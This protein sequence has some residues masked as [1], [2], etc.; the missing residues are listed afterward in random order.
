[1]AVEDRKQDWKKPESFKSASLQ[2]LVVA[3]LLAGAVFFYIQRG[4]RRKDIADL[5]KETRQAA[6]RDNPKDLEKALAIL[7]GVFR[8][9]SSQPDA[10][11]VA[12]DLHMER[13]MIHRLPGEEAKARDSLSKSEEEKS[14]VEERFGT[15][16]MLF[17]IDG[18]PR[19]ATTF[20]EDLRKRGASSARLWYVLARSHQAMGELGV[21]KQ[22]FSQAMDKAWKDP[23]FSTG[24]GEALIEEGQ[25]LHAFDAF[26]KA[27]SA[28]PDHFQAR[29]GRSLAAIY[30]KDRVKEAADT[31]AEILGREAELSPGLLARALTVKAELATFEGRPDDA[32]AAAN[33]ALSKNPEEYFALFAKAHALAAKKDA[34]TADAFNAAIAKRKTAPFFYFDAAQQLQA[35]G[36][37]DVALAVLGNYENAFRDVKLPTVD[38]KAIAALDRDDRYWLIKGDI[39]KAMDKLDDAMVAYDKA[40]AA[41]NVNLI[42]AHYAKGSVFFAKKDYDKAIEVL[43]PITPADGS[44]S[45]PDAYLTMGDTMFAKKVYDVGCQNYAFALTKLKTQQAPRERLNGILEDVNKRLIAAGQRPMAKQWMQEAKPLIQ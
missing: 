6:L 35:L 12:S 41:E 10:L 39:L 3:V 43:T 38:G 40:V 17:I 30:K 37:S 19:E 18:R 27:I 33:E 23:R 21:A 15:R 5:M 24:Y 31:L 7:E 16:A 26:S 32:L 4:Q 1:M 9:D 36:A 34:G 42:K 28:N 25:F 13:W 11:A 29:L 14:R 20:I 2:I 45:L 44:G 22:G 8:I